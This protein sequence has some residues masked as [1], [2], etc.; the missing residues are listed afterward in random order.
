L[1]IVDRS[2]A[3]ER[4]SDEASALK[5]RL[6]AAAAAATL[7]MLGIGATDYVKAEEASAS[8]DHYPLDQTGGI[9]VP[10]VDLDRYLATLEERASARRFLLT[11]G[12]L[13][14]A[15][16]SARIGDSQ[17]GELV[18]MADFLLAHPATVA[19]I[20]G[21]ADD[22]GDATTNSRLAAQRADAVRGYL[23]AQGIDPARLT[24][25]SRAE[26][27]PLLANRTQSDRAG[28]RRVAIVVQKSPLE[29]VP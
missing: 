5:V 17:K 19:L 15:A 24:I 8:R 27:S 16:G 6:W 28:N 26:D 14:F 18:R 1:I 13:L 9:A 22:R 21:Y 7:L 25:V 2:T 23:V 29:P 20:V 10:S 4:A 3:L 11:F 12:D